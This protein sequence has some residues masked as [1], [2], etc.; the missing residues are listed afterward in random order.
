MLAVGKILHL[1]HLSILPMYMQ[2]QA[3]Q[4]HRGLPTVLSKAKSSE[5]C[6]VTTK[7]FGVRKYPQANF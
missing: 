5:L 2:I 3:V 6:L 1:K 7:Q 4:T